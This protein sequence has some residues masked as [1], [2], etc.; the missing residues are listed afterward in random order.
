LIEY[1]TVVTENPPLDIDSRLDDV[2]N[3]PRD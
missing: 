3:S 2:L 1:F